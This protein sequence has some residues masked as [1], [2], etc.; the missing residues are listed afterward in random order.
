VNAAQKQVFIITRISCRRRICCGRCG[1]RR[2]GACG[3]IWWCRRRATTGT[4]PGPPARRTR[5]CWKPACA[6][7]SAGRRS[8]TRRR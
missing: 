2:C 4:R 7:S 3:S 5:T 8:S 1:W 6:S